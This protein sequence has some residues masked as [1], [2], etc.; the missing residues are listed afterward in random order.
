MQRRRP[1]RRSPAAACCVLADYALRLLVV[2]GLIF[3]SLRFFRLYNVVTTPRYCV[4]MT[5]HNVH[6]D[7][8]PPRPGAHEPF[9]V[10]YVRVDA[11]QSQVSWELLDGLHFEPA[12]LS[13]NGPLR[14][15]LLQSAAEFVALG[16]R[17]DGER[18]VGIV[19]VARE[20]IDEILARPSLFYI[21][22]R[23]SATGVEVVRDALGRTCFA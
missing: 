7:E 4:D 23:D 15:P 1:Q 14:A 10:G 6:A 18:L 2:G 8:L 22:V 20:K 11:A 13:I 9:A 3:V 21:S 19:D 5:R 12:S 16:V 17:R